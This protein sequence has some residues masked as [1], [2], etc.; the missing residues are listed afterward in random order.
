MCCKCGISTT[1]GKPWN[2]FEKANRWDTSTS[3]P[4]AKV[5]FLEL[6]VRIKEPP[7]NLARFL[8]W[9]GGGLKVN[10]STNECWVPTGLWSLW[11]LCLSSMMWNVEE[12]SV[13][14][15][16]RVLSKLKSSPG[17]D[18]SASPLAS[19]RHLHSMRWRQ[20]TWPEMDCEAFSNLWLSNFQLS[21]CVLCGV[22]HICT[23]NHSGES[24]HVIGFFPSPPSVLF[25]CL[26][27]MADSEMWARENTYDAC[28]RIHSKTGI[29][30]PGLV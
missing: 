8:W 21:K 15:D 7:H 19:A 4:T 2:D 5:V 3:D 16:L 11:E 24:P 13:T 12:S 14:H 30:N 25:Y 28:G 22:A 17:V 9:R 27:A 1:I 18:D 10:G 29:N 26:Y 6:K 23:Q 20:K